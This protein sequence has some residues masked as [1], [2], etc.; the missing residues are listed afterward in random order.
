[1]SLL[2]LERDPRIV[3]DYLLAMCQQ[4]YWDMVEMTRLEN[5][6]EHKDEDILNV[7]FRLTYLYKLTPFSYFCNI[8]IDEKMKIVKEQ[9]PTYLLGDN[10]LGALLKRDDDK[11]KEFLGVLNS[12]KVKVVVML[13]NDKLFIPTELHRNEEDFEYPVFLELPIK[14]LITLKQVPFF[15]KL[16]PVNMLDFNDLKKFEWVSCDTKS[17]YWVDTSLGFLVEMAIK[18]NQRDKLTCNRD[19]ILDIYSKY[20]I[21][22]ETLDNKVEHW[23]KSINDKIINYYILKLTY[24]YKT[25]YLPFEDLYKIITKPFHTVKHP[26][27]KRFLKYIKNIFNTQTFVSIMYRSIYDYVERTKDDILYNKLLE[28]LPALKLVKDET[29]DIQTLI[30]FTTEPEEYIAS[31]NK[32]PSDNICIECIKSLFLKKL[33]FLDR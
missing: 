22:I 26:Y 27:T 1:M 2:E 14:E 10:S 29:I 18:Y 17:C 19:F 13:E 6:K 28:E 25:K 33:K 21:K 23:L 7:L 24:N 15:K 8:T 32:K 11:I 30:I 3:K 31:L 4:T 20:L 12:Y 5:L 9:M 16:E